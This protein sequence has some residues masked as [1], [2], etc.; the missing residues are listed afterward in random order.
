MAAIMKFVALLAL[1]AVI[2]ANPV[3]KKRSISNLIDV[4][5]EY[6]L[7]FNDLS[8]E[9]DQ[10]LQFARVSLFATYSLMNQDL[11]KDLGH[12]RNAI[13]FG[14]DELIGD[15]AEEITEGGNEECLLNLTAQIRREQ[16]ELAETM[17]VCS[18]LTG[19]AKDDLSYSF[20]EF[21]DLLQRLSTALSE[22]VLWSFA[23]E[24]SVTHA[25]RQAENIR[26]MYEDSVEMW[27]EVVLPLIQFEIN[28]MEYNRPIIVANNKDCL[29]ILIEKVDLLNE[30]LREQLGSCSA[31][32]A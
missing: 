20:Y 27:D 30:E 7:L 10:L 13:E 28:A 1:V 26:Q 3:A 15:I 21:I 25:D 9:K 11:L 2:H 32:R 8:H 23:V 17:G 4:V 5:E 14:F 31:I 18:A 22:Y 24:N 29:D 19:S 6:K 16:V 12:T